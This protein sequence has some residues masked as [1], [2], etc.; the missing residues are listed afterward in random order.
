MPSCSVCL[1]PV[2]RG[3][4][5]PLS[6]SLVFELFLILG[7]NGYPVNSIC[8]FVLKLRRKKHNG[9]ICH[10][11]YFSLLFFLSFLFFSFL[12]FSFLSFLFFSFILVRSFSPT[13]S[14]FFSYVLLE[15]VG[16]WRKKKKKEIITL[17]SLGG[18]WKNSTSYVV[19]HKTLSCAPVV[20]YCSV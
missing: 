16:N 18:G 6:F 8:F 13:C 15:G 7:G 14:Q 1:M 19:S 10:V 2:V 17:T 9:S 3:M 5:P 4:F 11:L 12:F 20:N